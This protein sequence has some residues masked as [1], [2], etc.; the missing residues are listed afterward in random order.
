MASFLNE[1]DFPHPRFLVPQ[2]SGFQGRAMEP[3]F[4]TGTRSSNKTTIARELSATLSREPG[5]R[6]AETEPTTHSKDRVELRC[7]LRQ[8][9]W[10]RALC[11]C[12]TRADL[13]TPRDLRASPQHPESPPKQCVLTA[14]SCGPNFR[15]PGSQRTMRRFIILLLTVESW[16]WPS[17]S[18]HLAFT[19]EW[20][21]K[22]LLPSTLVLCKAS[23]STGGRRDHFVSETEGK[24]SPNYKPGKMKLNTESYRLPFK[25]W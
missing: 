6:D 12:P 13:R 17:T 22:N 2:V 23:T 11:P 19:V 21:L 20:K 15:S 25:N 24:M 8:R 16:K 14:P 3:E 1:A 10:I 7:G 18:P 5:A 9:A 4:R